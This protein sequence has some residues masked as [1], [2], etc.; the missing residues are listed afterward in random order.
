MIAPTVIV[1][2]QINIVG[3]AIGRPFFMAFSA[4]SGRADAI[5]VLVQLK[6]AS[7]RNGNI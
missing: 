6:C 7:E 3:A 2:T 5:I 4:A 1:G